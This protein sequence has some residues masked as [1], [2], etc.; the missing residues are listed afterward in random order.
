MKKGLGVLLALCLLAAMPLL[1]PACEE[2]EA[3]EGQL[4]S[5][6]TGDKWV[7]SYVTDE[8]TATLTEEI[9]GEEPLD[10]LLIPPRFFHSL[11]PAERFPGDSQRGRHH[12]VLQEGTPLF[13]LLPQKPF[14]EATPNLFS[15]QAAGSGH[16][17]CLPKEVDFSGAGNEAVKVVAHNGLLS[18]TA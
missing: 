17:G 13:F 2:E 5:W 7:W 4:P 15:L 10:Q 9:I 6:E 3:P 16:G 18:F 1:L 12:G 8:T 11:R 14:D